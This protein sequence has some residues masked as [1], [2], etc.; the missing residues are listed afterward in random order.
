MASKR[1]STT[2][3]M[4]P[5]KALA[6]D[7]GTD[8]AEEE[9]DQSSTEEHQ[10]I[11]PAADLMGGGHDL[12]SN[13]HENVEGLS[14]FCK[15]CNFGSLETSPFVEHMN[16]KHLDFRNDPSYVCIVCSFLVK[17]PKEL[18][19]HNAD[20][21]PGDPDLS[22][23]VAKHE[24]YT[25]VEQS[26]SGHGIDHDD[27]VHHGDE[28]VDDYSEVTM[29]KTPIM[30]HFK[31][32][33]ETKKIITIKDNGNCVGEE[34]ERKGRPVTRSGTALVSKVTNNIVN[35]SPLVNGPI[36]GTV[37]VLQTGVTQLV[38][39]NPP[40]SL[41]QPKIPATIITPV[42]PK[43]SAQKS[44][45]H[46]LPNEKSLPRVMIPLSSIP[47]YNSSMDSNCFLKN[48][49]NKFP[50][51]LKAELCY[52]TVVTKYPEEQIKIWFTAQRLKQ[53]ISWSPEEIEDSRKKMFNTIIQSIPQPMQ[54]PT[55]TVLNAPLVT[56]ANNVQHLIHATLPSQIVSQPQGTG[57]V[58]VTQPILSNGIQ[59][60]LTSVSLGI[61]PLSTSQ[62]NDFGRESFT[63]AGNSP[64]ITSQS[65][66]Y[67]SIRIK[68][69]RQQLSALKNSFCK[70]QFPSHGEVAKLTRITGLSTRDVRK[71]FS[72][73]RYHYRNKP[74][75]YFSDTGEPLTD[76]QTDLV[77]S[78][79]KEHDTDFALPASSHTPAHTPRRQSW[80]QTPDFT[81]TRY[82][83]RAPEQLRVLESSF[84]TNTFPSDDEVTRLRSETK[85]TRREIDSWFADKR[86]RV[87]EELKREKARYEKHEDIFPEEMETFRVKTADEVKAPS[88]PVFERKVNPIKINLKALRV[89]DTGNNTDS[90]RD[91]NSNHSDG[92]S[93]R[94]CTPQKSRSVKKTAQQRDHLR[95]LFVKTQWPSQ[96][97]YDNLVE[98]TGLPRPEIVRW[99]GDAR[100]SFKIGNLRW[101]E[102]YKKTYSE[103][104]PASLQPLLDYY[105]EHQT[106]CETDINDLCDQTA[107]SADDI[108]SWFSERMEEAKRGAVEEGG[109]D[110][111]VSHGDTVDDQNTTPDQSPKVSEN[112]DSCEPR[113]D[114]SLP[115]QP[116]S[117]LPLETG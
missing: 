110:A 39:I 100:Y 62:A 69:S 112:G 105:G 60:A 6:L 84:A 95:Q 22:W 49:F 73:K 4:I 24:S 80:H 36:I 103:A 82:K 91:D 57:G 30:K 44:Q 99:F 116:P 61:A 63:A 79:G 108:R 17:D 114:E 102:G 75:S 29:T 64:P 54:Q 25:V 8:M 47:T 85:M 18:E 21:H 7:G 77:F 83:E 117:D 28:L 67:E 10:D 81:T 5:L 113:S 13:G 40:Q 92:G 66:F 87:A 52:L 42:L 31:N 65:S 115:E 74:A 106:L 90:F 14:F 23:I 98:Q 104:K 86:K 78:V 72:D 37:P 96:E 50:Y 111:N 41:I 45:S 19:A 68:K 59:G 1:K 88:S 107:M 48:S 38:S 93:S 89:T 16:T 34:P 2:P 71:W 58:I 56:N 27:P 3:C 55:I 26:V 20:S 97:Q 11:L 51:P 12:L 46:L 94:P 35:S 70:S 32:K 101:Y 15:Y 33:L 53:G 76:A 9:K 109:D 43:Q